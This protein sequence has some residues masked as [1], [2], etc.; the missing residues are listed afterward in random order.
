[1]MGTVAAALH[2]AAYQNSWAQGWTDIRF[3]TG[4][5]MLLV[6]TTAG[7]LQAWNIHMLPDVA[8]RSSKTVNNNKIEID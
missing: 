3:D 4:M 5:I 2:I 1:M 7:P 8:Q 6:S